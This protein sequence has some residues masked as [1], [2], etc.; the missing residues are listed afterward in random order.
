MSETIPFIAALTGLAGTIGGVLISYLTLRHTF[1]RNR[2]TVKLN[3]AKSLMV[4]QQ[5]QPKKAKLSDDLL[6]FMVANVGPKEYTV[7]QIGLE[8][9]RRTS[10][11]IIPDPSGTVKVPYKLQP[12]ETCNFWTEYEKITKGIEK[13]RLYGTIKVRGYVMDYIGNTFYSNRL[14][15]VIKETLVSR[16]KNK[17]NKLFK[18]FLTLIQP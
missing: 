3:I 14:K 9:G 1:N 6:T 11:R 5:T 7:T 16:L 8:I 10:G 13:P 4:T 2:H 17:L 12:D 18:G 15:I